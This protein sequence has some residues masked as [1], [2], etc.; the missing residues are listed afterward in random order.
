VAWRTRADRGPL[1][2]P[3]G[4]PKPVLWALVPM[5]F[6]GWV[7]TLAGWY[8]TEIGRQ[9]WLVQGVHDD[10]RHGRHRRARA[11]GPWGRWHLPAIYAALLAAYLGVIVYLARK[12]AK[13]E[14]APPRRHDPFGQGRSKQSAPRSEVAHAADFSNPAD[15]LPWA[16]ASLMG[17]S[18]L[19]T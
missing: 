10:G 6:S 15:W 7:A 12:A 9:P 16:F 8:T 1:V 3:E 19:S 17:L 13:G 4:L 5:A 18:I 2:R 14:D 11:D